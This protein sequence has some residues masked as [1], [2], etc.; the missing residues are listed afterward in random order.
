MLLRRTKAEPPDRPLLPTSAPPTPWKGPGRRCV[1]LSSLCALACAAIMGMTTMLLSPQQS[2]LSATYLLAS[3]L[4]HGAPNGHADG[5]LL[6]PRPPPRPDPRVPPLPWPGSAAISA[7]LQGLPVQSSYHRCDLMDWHHVAADEAHRWEHKP[8]WNYHDTGAC[9]EYDRSLSSAEHVQ[10]ETQ[11]YRDLQVDLA[12]F[13]IHHVRH[14][15]E[16]Q[17]G[18]VGGHVFVRQENCFRRPHLAHTDSHVG[19]VVHERYGPASMELRVNG[20]EL[21]TIPI[22]FIE[23]STYAPLH[24]AIMQAGSARKTVVPEGDGLTGSEAADH[25]W[26]PADVEW[27]GPADE[28]GHRLAQPGI[29]RNWTERVQGVDVCLYEA[30]YSVSLHG[31][32]EVRVLLMHVDFEDVGYMGHRV[33][34]HRSQNAVLYRVAPR[35]LA[36]SPRVYW[37]HP[38]DTSAV[39]PALYARAAPAFA[40]VDFCAD[41]RLQ[42]DADLP[43]N[44]ARLFNMP[45]EIQRPEWMAIVIGQSTLL[46]NPGYDGRWI[47][48]SDAALHNPP[49]IVSTMITNVWWDRD[50][51]TRRERM[52]EYSVQRPP[53]FF[54]AIQDPAQYVYVP[55]TYTHQQLPPPHHHAVHPSAVAVAADRAEAAADVG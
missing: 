5:V 21:H 55:Y 23:P 14:V 13:T 1:L 16:G 2:A 17:E 44:T 12:F 11:L 30:D 19:K 18:D 34:L 8:D 47:N 53:F 50:N 27:P 46:Q 37:P 35:R 25:E 22:T 52:R 24:V 51:D 15:G 32:Y 4:T 29:R 28:L 20:T 3:P 45:L 26:L 31:V 9:V 38:P 43:W 7:A 6:T 39:H 41:D 48:V 54:C 33:S 40:R 10:L 49:D 36:P 42:Y